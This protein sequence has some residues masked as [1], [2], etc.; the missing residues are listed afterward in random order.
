MSSP[1]ILAALLA[2][3]QAP[4][5]LIVVLDDVA[6]AD[7]ALYGGPAATPHLAALAAA[8]EPFAL[9]PADLP[10]FRRTEEFQRTAERS[11]VASA[12]AFAPPPFTAPSYAPPPFEAPA[13]RPAAFET[14]TPSTPAPR[15]RWRTPVA[16]AAAG[17]VGLFLTA[18]AA[19]LIGHE[20]RNESRRAYREQ[21]VAFQP[22]PRAWPS[23]SQRERK[24]LDLAQG[25]SEDFGG[26]EEAQPTS[27]IGRASCRE[28]V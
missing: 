6:A 4:D 28:R 3:A 26:E 27:E 2:L 1:T 17:V 25:V 14:S 10:S 18:S 13:A 9:R 24:V 5:V 19:A 23:L 21:P 20:A 7:L 22:A 11:P 8:P 15:R 16:L 12:P